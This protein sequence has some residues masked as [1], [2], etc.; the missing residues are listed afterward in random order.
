MSTRRTIKR[1]T[2]VAKQTKFGK[3]KKAASGG[4]RVV[5]TVHFF[6]WL[7]ILVAIAAH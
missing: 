5:K 2:R 7:A 6:V 4:E 1:T 3:R